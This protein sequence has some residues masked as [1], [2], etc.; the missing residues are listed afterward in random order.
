MRSFAILAVLSLSAGN[1]VWA[2]S[3]DCAAQSD[4][5]MSLVEGR[6]DGVPRD[7]AES[8]AVATLD[9]NAGALLAEWVYTL[10]E[11]QLTDAIGVAWK[12]QCE[13]M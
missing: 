1:P 12:T 6:K 11:D 4:F 5:V 8:S 13:A 9:E 10:P 7:E 3:M 2:E